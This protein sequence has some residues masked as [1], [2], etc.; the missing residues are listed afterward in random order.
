LFA[1]PR[2]WTIPTDGYGGCE[3]YALTKRKDLIA[4]GFP[5]PTLRIAVVVTPRE[6]RHAVLTVATDK[7]DFVLDNLRDDVVAWNATGHTWIE[8]QDPSRPLAW[9]SLEQP[10]RMIAANSA[11]TQSQ[12]VASSGMATGSAE[13]VS[14]TSNR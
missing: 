4:D 5:E 14:S 13:P 8:R 9:V 12:P 3:D 11:D 1:H 6:A 10:A 7:G 2:S